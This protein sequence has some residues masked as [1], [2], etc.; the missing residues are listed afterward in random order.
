MKLFGILFYLSTSCFINFVATSRAL[1]DDAFP[2]R[3]EGLWEISISSDKTTTVMKQCIDEKTDSKLQQMGSQVGQ[4]CTRMQTR[5]E[6]SSYVS[7]ADCEMAGSR[8][9][10][11]AV[12]T[13]D[14][15]SSYQGDVSATYD[16]PLMGKSE[17][18]TRISAKRLGACAADQR[19]GDIILPD[20]T[21]MNM[22]MLGKAAAPG[23]GRRQ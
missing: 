1:A 16:P 13:G 20:G 15:S 3:M 10:S 4:N 12:I 19:P 8:I 6:G 23:K 9:R 2:R 7:E 17:G 18:K 11:R 21:K 22:D 5:K 14:F